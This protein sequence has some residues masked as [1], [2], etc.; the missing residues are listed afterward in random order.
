MRCERIYNWYKNSCVSFTDGFYGSI[1]ASVTESA[2]D[3]NFILSQT[4]HNIDC[5]ERRANVDRDS[6]NQ[7][8][9]SPGCFLRPLTF[10]DRNAQMAWK[11]R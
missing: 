4:Q 9:K 5:S 8:P 11:H 1:T 10:F 2:E 7:K 6:G 3:E